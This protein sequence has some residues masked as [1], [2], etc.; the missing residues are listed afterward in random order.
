MDMAKTSALFRIHFVRASH[1]GHSLRSRTHSLR[2]CFA[3]AGRDL[4]PFS[5]AEAHRSRASLEGILHEISCLSVIRGRIS[6]IECEFTNDSL[7]A[8]FGRALRTEGLAFQSHA[9]AGRASSMPAPN[10]ENCFR[11]RSE[12]PSYHCATY[13]RSALHFISY[14]RDRH[15]FTN[16]S[17]P[18]FFFDRSGRG[19]C[20][21]STIAPSGKVNVGMKWPAELRSAGA[22]FGA[23]RS[24]N[25]RSS[26]FIK[27]SHGDLAFGSLIH[28]ANVT[29]RNRLPSLYIPTIPRGGLAGDRRLQ[30]RG[31]E[32]GELL[33]FQ[34]RWRWRCPPP[35][36]PYRDMAEATT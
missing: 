7:R 35:L 29:K 3:P 27:P 32:R 9:G 11:E 25:I 8:P 19:A 12:C 13:G 28:E 22:L 1:P 15:R 26:H 4:P 34:W 2:S 16:G 21:R 36:P 24:H 14:V 31:G 33:A 10:E 6:T 20:A 30:L 23:L 5:T 17:F 18:S